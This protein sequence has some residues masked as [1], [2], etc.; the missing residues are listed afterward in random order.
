MELV[1]IIVPIYNVEKYLP[2]CIESLT[3]QTMKNLEI[4]LI[5]D[6]SLDNSLAICHDYAKKDERIRVIDKKNEGVAVAR[7]TGLE[8][9]KGDY[10]GFVDPDD[11]IEAGMYQSMYQKLIQTGGEICFCNY[12]KDD[13]LGSSQ[14]LL[15]IKKEILNRQEIIDEMIANMIGIDDLMPKYNYI[16]GCVWRCLYKKDFIDKYELRFKRG[17]SIMEDLV[18]T[19][20]ALLKCHS[21]CIDKG[22]WYHYRRN[23]KS[24][25]HTYNPRMWEDQIYVH[26]L[27]EVLLAEVGLGEYMSNRL[28]LRYIG[29]AFSAIYNATN[30]TTQESKTQIKQRMT[31]VRQICADE[32]LK[33]ALDRVKP[34][35]RPTL[36]NQENVK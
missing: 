22:I 32:R 7:N 18:F 33:L 16:M 12:Y 21:I 30:K 11:W 4:L 17:L 28:D 23:P 6:G 29:M 1:S 2:K 8:E 20:E 14:K 26:Q 31:R 19:I 5:N 27:L 3:K 13:K 36:F 34:I 25:L 15:K 10:I 9:A 24:T 35:Q